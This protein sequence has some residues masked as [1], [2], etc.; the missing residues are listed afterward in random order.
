MRQVL[1]R[2]GSTTLFADAEAGRLDLFMQVEGPLLPN[3]MR[4]IGLTLMFDELG[5]FERAVTSA[6]YV[7]KPKRKGKT[8]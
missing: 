6:M 5:Q 3:Q 8:K 4:Q 2:I 1:A 7:A